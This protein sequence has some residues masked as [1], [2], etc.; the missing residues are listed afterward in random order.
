[1]IKTLALAGLTLAVALAPAVAQDTAEQIENLLGDSAA[2]YELLDT[3]Q[4]AMEE[5]DAETV[6]GLV[7]Y[8]FTARINDAPVE[9]TEEDEF[10]SQY[11]TLF[12]P[13]VREVILNADP[14]SLFVNSEGVMLGSGEVWL[15]PVCV[16]EACSEATWEILAINN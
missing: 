4:T 6:A 10:K 7:S 11:D 2:F 9:L 8:P 5:R 13:N 16:D 15:S 1:M 14:D 12:A 3:L